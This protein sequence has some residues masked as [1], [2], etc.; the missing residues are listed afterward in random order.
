M[1][2]DWTDRWL[3]QCS[4]GNVGSWKRFGLSFLLSHLE[5]TESGILRTF[6]EFWVLELVIAGVLV[7]GYALARAELICFQV[8]EGFTLFFRL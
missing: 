6:E 8:I 5:V 2:H 4:G 1:E 7:S 3:E